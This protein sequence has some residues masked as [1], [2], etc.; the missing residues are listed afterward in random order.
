M[1]TPD[2]TAGSVRELVEA[3]DRITDVAARFRLDGRRYVVLG[4]G[5]GMGRHTA[6]QLTQ[7]GAE[8]VAGRGHTW[9]LIEPGHP[10]SVAA[11]DSLGRFVRERAERDATG[12]RPE[13]SPPVGRQ[14]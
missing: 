14:A 9:P 2:A 3:A 6:H 13:V 11:L 8:I 1:T 10:D 12:H 5:R 7:L 4:G